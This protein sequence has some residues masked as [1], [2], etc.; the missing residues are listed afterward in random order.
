L[1]LLQVLQGWE[2]NQLLVK[3]IE[4]DSLTKR[5]VHVRKNTKINFTFLLKKI[6]VLGVNSQ[7][8]CT[9]RDRERNLMFNNLIQF[10]QQPSFP[11]ETHHKN[12]QKSRKS[13]YL[14][15]WL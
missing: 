7:C 13:K 4:N 6:A 15:Q 8:Q 9:V 10:I 12:L 3:L 11:Q 5:D 14:S 1:K 2:E